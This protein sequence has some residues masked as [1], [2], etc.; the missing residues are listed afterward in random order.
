MKLDFFVKL[1]KW[2]ST[3]I[4]CVCITYSLLDLLFDVN[5]WPTSSDMRQIQ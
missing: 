3:T 1:K 2:S 5:N 4:W